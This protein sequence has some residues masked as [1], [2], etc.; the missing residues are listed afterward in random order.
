MLNTVSI[1]GRLTASPELKTTQSGKSV[2]SFTIAND[3]GY[4]E[5]KQTNWIDAV[6]WNGCAETIAKC[7]TKGSRIAITG[8]LQTRS[9]E[10][11]NGNKRK[12]C[13]VIVTDFDFVDKKSEGSEAPAE[14]QEFSNA[15][16]DDFTEIPD[17]DLPF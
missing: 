9:Y 8:R 1:M 17:E 15:G 5:H 13:E 2:C 14:A 4:S 3:T 7:F 10:D 16:S 12:V 6:A 11:K